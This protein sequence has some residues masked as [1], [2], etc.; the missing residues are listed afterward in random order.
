MMRDFKRK[1][2]IGKFFESKLTL[3]LLFIF[4]ILFAWNV[5]GFISKMSETTRNKKIAE[6]KVL[7]LE[8][9]KE[10]L[11]ED[12]NSLNTEKGQEESIREKFGFVKEG[13]EV[14]VIVEERTEVNKEEKKENKFLNFLRNWFK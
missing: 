12:I 3:F 7:E 6:R 1:K 14:I 4:L 2:G 13:E 8:E 11:T 9:M 5:F 10:K